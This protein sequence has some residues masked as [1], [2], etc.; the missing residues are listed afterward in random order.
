M[1]DFSVSP[2]AQNVK[3][4]AS[5]SLAD[6][7]NLARSGQA[8][9]QAQQI[10]P[11][12]VQKSR[13]ELSRLQQL[14]P[15][16]LAIKIAERERAEIEAGVSAGTSKSRI[17]TSQST[18]SS[19]ASTAEQDRIKLFAA[20]QKKINDSQISMINNKLILDA[21][22]NPNA[23]DKLALINLVRQN[24][25]NMAKDLD[26]KHDE[27]MKLLQPYLDIAINDPGRLRGFL[28]ERHIQAL[29]DAARTA[30]LQPSGIAVD[31]GTGGYVASTNEFSAFRPGVAL[32]GLSYGRQLMLNESMG[33]DAANNP[34]IITKNSNG[35]ITIRP[36]DQAGESGAVFPS[37][38]GPSSSAPAAAPPSA[39]PSV[40]P[41]PAKV[42]P[43]VGDGSAVA[44]KQSSL[45]ANLPAGQTNANLPDY[46]VQVP[47]RFPVPVAGKPKMSFQL[48]E[49]EAQAAG[50]DY[51]RNI[52]SQRGA[53]APVRNNLEKIMSTTDELLAKQGFQAGKG[54]QVEQYF[55]KLIDDSEY[56][57]LS[58]NLANLQIALI[59]NNPQALSSDAG[60]QMTAAAS[61]S[62]VYP[63]KV[64]QKIVIQLHGEMENR[65][66]QGV[67]ADKYARKFGE[68]NMASFTQMWNNNSDNKVFELMSLPKLVKDPA[69]RAKMADEIIGYP[70]NSEQRKVFEQ[71]YK[72]I[73]KL[74]KD[75]TL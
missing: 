70:R 65:D 17:D 59:G 53:V 34:I 62:E 23:V 46:S 6:M 44:P 25:M 28:K 19:S 56:K 35:Q 37:G 52:I 68:S 30:A 63:P 45:V 33:L 20:K 11:L 69:L 41:A 64:L 47:P 27:A 54:L 38:Q 2:V 1:A 39:A 74:I 71:K 58:K 40:V 43:R 48:G 51:V 75:G 16:E 49:K 73:Q 22:K 24:G 4:P 29:D 13:T 32:P 31:Y 57:T 72:N 3:P 61:G 50:G 36:V 7:V 21:E 12:E 8:F 9:Q 26:I 55:T 10:N 18:A 60:K 67:A 15:E 5:M 66:R 14:I 42:A